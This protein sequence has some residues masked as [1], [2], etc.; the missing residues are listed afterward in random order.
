MATKFSTEKLVL[1]GLTRDDT[2]YDWLV[3]YAAQQ[4]LTFDLLYQ[5]S[6]VAESYGAYQ[7]PTYILIDQLGQIR[8]RDPGYY[9]YR[10]SEL[11]QRIQRL[12]APNLILTAG[13]GKKMGTD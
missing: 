13:S 3:E 11:V 1:L 2:P 12:L 7:D 8:F 9:F 5:A 6:A 4:R 10:S